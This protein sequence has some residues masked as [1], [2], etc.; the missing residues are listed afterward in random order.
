MGFALVAERDG[1]RVVNWKATLIALAM[2][3]GLLTLAFSF[4][5][6][7]TGKSLFGLIGVKGPLSV[8]ARLVLSILIVNGAV[9]YT[10]STRHQPEALPRTPRATVFLPSA[11]RGWRIGRRLIYATVLALGWCAF[12]VNWLTPWLRGKSDKVQVQQIAARNAGTGALIAK[13]PNG[14]SM[15]LLTLADAGATPNAWWRPDGKPLPMTS[16]EM[17]TSGRMNVPSAV[18]KDLIFRFV[19]LP[20]GMTF[21]LI[22]STPASG[23]STG[24]TVRR[25][26]QLLDN[27]WP[28]RMGWPA[29]VRKATLRLGVTLE[30]WR[31]IGSYD[32][33]SHT[34][35]STRRAGDPN[36]QVTFH[37]ATE[38][39]ENT[40]VTIMR[41]LD[42]AK[43]Q[44][45]IVAVDA[46]GVEHPDTGGTGTS[47]NATQAW[48]HTFHIPLAQVKEFRAQI[49]P[50]YWVEFRDVA[51][52]RAGSAADP[53][54]TAND[55]I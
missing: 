40:A 24:D 45:R 20:E 51:L 2:V 50:I 36:W 13:L 9:Q 21:P 43:W 6:V 19:N 54:S 30:S 10:M 15:E 8:L 26:S 53:R 28:V 39:G 25:N 34:T 33:I 12:Q 18:E 1:V 37:Q 23:H 7:F 3:F 22:E 48:T 42:D 38:S 46:N 41:G 4:V 49:R 11:A 16:F 31:T 29:S 35:S 55:L 5:T 27:A 14:G 52:R 17:K 32:Q 44:T 47:S